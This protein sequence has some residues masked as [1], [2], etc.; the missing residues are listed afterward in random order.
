MLKQ[1]VHSLG[2]IFRRYRGGGSVK[3][4]ADIVFSRDRNYNDEN[5]SISESKCL[6]QIRKVT[7]QTI[8]A[9]NRLSQRCLKRKYLTLLSFLKHN[10]LL[11][12]KRNYMYMS[13][14]SLFEHNVWCILQL[15]FNKVLKYFLLE[16]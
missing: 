14:L 12:C 11:Y 3:Y 8:N 1:G 5:A 10:V 13:S 4:C 2:K 6:L 16:T 7:S 15:L 9:S